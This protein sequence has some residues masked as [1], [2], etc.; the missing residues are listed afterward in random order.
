MLGLFQSRLE[1]DEGRYT[2]AL[3]HAAAAYNTLAGT[4]NELR[5]IA[6]SNLASVSMASG[7]LDAAHTLALVLAASDAPVDL[8]EI[9]RATVTALEVSA[10]GNLTEYQAE[11]QRMEDEHRAAGQ[12]HYL[13]VTMLNAG[14][15]AEMRGDAALALEK[16]AFAERLLRDGRR[17]NELVAA[18]MIHA[19]AIAHLGD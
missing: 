7:E 14:Y 1:L 6:L 17:R 11:L 2:A 5:H 19:W 10:R 4:P 12:L 18:R 9:A 13:G 8:Q 16:S 15:V 3:A